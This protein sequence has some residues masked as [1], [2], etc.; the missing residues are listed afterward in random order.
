MF[1]WILP[2]HERGLSAAQCTHQSLFLKRAAAKATTL[3]KRAYSTHCGASAEQEMKVLLLLPEQPQKRGH[4]G[5]SSCRE[6]QPEVPRVP[7]GTEETLDRHHDS[8]FDLEH[9][10][11]SFLLEMA[12]QIRG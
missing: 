6:G 11:T 10:I 12:A 9:V 4:S 8:R 3:S 7:V 1:I 5:E 2:E